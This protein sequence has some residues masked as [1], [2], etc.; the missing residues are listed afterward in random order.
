MFVFIKSVVVGMFAIFPGI[1]GSA[2]AISLNIYDRF[3]Y[4]LKNIQKN[5]IYLLSVVIGISLGII[6]GSNI[7]IYLSGIKNFLYFFFTGLIVSDLPFM[8]KKVKTRGK[9]R[10]ILLICSFLLSTATMVLCKNTINNDTTTIK[11]LLGGLF[12]AFG[13][14]FPGISSSF[15]LMLLGIYREILILLSNPTVLFKNFIY[16][17]PFI[18]GVLIGLLIFV[19]LLNYLLDKKYDVLYSSLIGF[20]I[21]SIIFVFPKFDFSFASIIGL[22]LM[23]ISTVISFKIRAKKEI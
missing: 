18:I 5:I 11:M 16:Y 9:I 22:L 7:I 19:K 8:V 20:M 6:I 15:F 17:L 2:L 23:I 14:I 12:F 4:S 3:F 10:Y 21:S 1:S 13:K